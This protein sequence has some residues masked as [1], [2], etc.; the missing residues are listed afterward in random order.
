[1]GGNVDLIEHGK[2]GMLCKAEDAADLARVVLEFYEQALRAPIKD[3]MTKN[4]DLF[5]WTPAKEAVFF[6][7]S[8]N[9]Q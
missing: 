7:Q 4:A 9:Q 8:T 1:V 2:T 6:N 5:R 3:G